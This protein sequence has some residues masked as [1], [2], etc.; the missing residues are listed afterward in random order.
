MKAVIDTNVLVSS[1]WKP[2]GNARLVT[3][4]IICGLVTPCYDSRIMSEYRIVIAR[5]KFRFPP[6]EVQYLLS[7]IID[8]VR[9]TPI[10]DAD[11]KDEDGR[12]FYEVAKYCNAP[13]VTGNIKH[14]PDDPIVMSLAD[15]CSLYLKG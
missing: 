9:P 14:F 12:A 13:L 11:V 8:Y 7:V 4:S 6:E 15:F 1:I 2:S 10:P 5:P 3:S